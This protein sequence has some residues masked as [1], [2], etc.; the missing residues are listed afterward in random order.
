MWLN[1]LRIL[2]INRDLSLTRHSQCKL[3]F[4]LFYIPSQRLKRNLMMR[5]RVTE[6]ADP[7]PLP[8]AK[9]LLWSCEWWAV[10]WVNG[11]ST[12]IEKKKSISPQILHKSKF[13]NIINSICS[14]L[15]I[16]NTVSSGC[17]VTLLCTNTQKNNK[18]KKFLAI[19]NWK[20]IV[21]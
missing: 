7:P 5:R 3:K 10:D 2:Q 14:S 4:F 12:L 13:K 6:Q 18:T 17:Y 11:R 9:V 1:L 8:S 15:C 20:I 21:S 19:F 16:P